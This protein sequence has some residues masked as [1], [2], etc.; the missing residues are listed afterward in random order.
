MQFWG[1]SAEDRETRSVG[2]EGQLQGD[3]ITLLMV[4]QAQ[5]AEDREIRQEEMEVQSLEDKV[6]LPAVV[7]AVLV[8]V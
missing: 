3:R 2:I 5:S 1:Q 8:E 6:I 7:I 4:L